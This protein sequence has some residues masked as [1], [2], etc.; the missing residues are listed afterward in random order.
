[1]LLEPKTHDVGHMAVGRI[2][3]SR[4][5]RTV[6][7]YVF[8]DHIGPAVLAEGV[9]VDVAPHPHIGLSTMTYLFEGELDHRDSTGVH[10]VIRP[11]AVNWMTAGRGV[12]HSERSNHDARKRALPMHGIQVW[13]GLPQADE[14]CAPS[15]R[16][17]AA[18]EFPTAEREGVQLRVIAGEAFGLNSP[19]F[20]YSPLFCVDMQMPVG[21]RV[22]VEAA[23]S[24]V[25]CFVASGDVT[26]GAEQVPAGQALVLG[27]GEQPVVEVRSDSRVIL[28]GGEPLDGVR[29]L[30]WNLVSSRKERLDQGEADW[31][32]G[33]FPVVP[34]DENDFVP[35]PT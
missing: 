8:F 13:I 33:R 31:K 21:S 34:G 7:P 30:R 29:Y 24:E 4:A 26:V 17:Y 15:F 12:V 23:Y 14:E 5:R 6:G 11:G 20:T 22:P 25:A 35:W 3:P 28:F 10:Q 32:A 2:L 27:P 18:A 19:L 9:G 1:M 16:H